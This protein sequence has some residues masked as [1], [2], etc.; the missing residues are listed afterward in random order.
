MGTI[1]SKKNLIFVLCAVL[2][3][4]SIAFGIYKKYFW[5]IA[6][7]IFAPPEDITEFFPNDSVP[8]KAINETN[9]PLRLPPGFT[10]SI[11]AK[12]LPGARVMKIDTFGNM[13]VSRTSEGAV[14]LL[15]IDRNSGKV[16]QQN[17]IFT[18]LRK[19]H[20]LAFAPDNQ[21]LLYIAEEDKIRRVTMYSDDSGEDVI[22]LPAGDGHFTRT[23]GFGPDNKLYIS[24]GSSCNVCNESDERRA[25]IIQYD[26]QAKTSKIF[27]KGLRNA[28]FFIWNSVWPNAN[29][30][31]WATEMGRDWLGDDLPPDEI[32]I[33]RGPS[34]S[35][36]QE[37]EARSVGAAGQNSIPNFGWPNCYGKN[38]HDTDFD[39]NTYI[40]NPCI[41]PFET[42]SLIDL[43][44]HSAPLGLAFIPKGHPSAGSGQ[45]W[46]EDYWYDLL[47]AYHGSW[48]RSQPTGYK[49]VRYKFDADGNY[50]GA[51]DFVTGWLVKEGALGRPVDILFGQD[52]S[53]YISDDKAGV[54]Y[55]ITYGKKMAAEIVKSD[56]IHVTKPKAGELIKS[57]LVV[58]GEARGNWFFE[59]SFPVR[60]IDA[61]GKEITRIHADALSDWMTTEFVPYKA[62]V[63][64]KEPDAL[65]GELILEKDNPSGLP[66][67]YDELRIPVRFR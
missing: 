54:I 44:A 32:N 37:S 50:Q 12:N 63:E 61:N 51:E 10:I 29:N 40:R 64:F 19:P 67:N 4:V 55:K 28:V 56:K 36:R 52:G 1:L 7:A 26:V 31:M 3:F 39:K 66:E 62:T 58:E 59:A 6:P 5:G 49:V 41:E 25:S 60:L 47:V 22:S 42:G 11:F 38:I 8:A 45:A 43:P 48:N 17:D 24:A 13:W 65:T 53:A 9:F 33:I 18:G 46:P 34:T 14:S 2:V 35:S 16:A 20:G 21:F 27:A 30:E 23:I 15:E 57:P